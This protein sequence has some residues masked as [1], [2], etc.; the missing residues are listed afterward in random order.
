[1]LSVTSRLIFPRAQESPQRYKLADV[2]GVVV[3]R[4][5]SFAQDS[6]AV[7][8]GQRRKKISLGIGN[9]LLYSRQVSLK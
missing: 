7:S 4:E 1:M 5:Q 3:S 2:V 6:L 9:Q 8:P